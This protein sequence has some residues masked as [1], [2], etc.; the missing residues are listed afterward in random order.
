MT[1]PFDRGLLASLAQ[2]EHLRLGTPAG[3][4]ERVSGLWFVIHQGFLYIRSARGERAA[5]YRILRDHPLATLHV[6]RLHL[7][8]R[9]VSVQE[10]EVRQRISA[11]LRQKYAYLHPPSLQLD[12]QG[13]KTTLRLEPAEGEQ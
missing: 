4:R 7:S 3:S 10:D 11:H 6:G 12:E 2:Q 13:V 9:A 5:W 8:I 1:T